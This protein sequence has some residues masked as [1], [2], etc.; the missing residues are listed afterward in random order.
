V[1][2]P[3]LPASKAPLFVDSGDA[4]T[5]HHNLTPP[6]F[7]CTVPSKE[8]YEKDP[9][10]LFTSVQLCSHLFTGTSSAAAKAPP[11]VHVHLF[12]RDAP[13]LALVDV[14]SGVTR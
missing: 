13:A 14:T 6:P 1:P 2:S 5:P 3:D 9:V 10:K 11:L 12:G 7:V 8:D 4:F